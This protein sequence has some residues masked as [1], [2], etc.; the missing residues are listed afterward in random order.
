MQAT[1]GRDGSDCARP[2]M[3]LIRPCKLRISSSPR[4][5]ASSASATRS[6]SVH[7]SA[8]ALGCSDT[9]CGQA[10]SHEQT[11]RSTSRRLTAHTSHCDCVTI[12][13]GSS[14]RSRSLVHA[15]DRQGVAQ[16][17]LDALVD[18]AAG[19]FHVELR[20]RA[21][22][23]A[24]NRLGIVAFVGAA[25]ELVLEAEGADD[26]GGAGDQGDDAGH[27]GSSATLFLFHFFASF[28]ITL[29]YPLV[30]REDTLHSA[31]R[32]RQPGTAP[33]SNLHLRSVPLLHSLPLHCG[34]RPIP[35]RPRRVPSKSGERPC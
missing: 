33:T 16:D 14:S 20:R 22:G 26:L 25:D 6:T 15:V 8:R 18:L 4:S 31:Q 2:A 1:V 5:R 24:T 23:Q 30:R 7:T 10:D 32:L 21:D 3:A 27:D 35:S 34:P 12:T 13:S 29:L 19:A 11:A 9:S 28:C 17:R